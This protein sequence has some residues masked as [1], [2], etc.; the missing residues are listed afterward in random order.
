M[1]M[2][3]YE[4]LILARQDF[5]Q[6]AEDGDCSGDCDYCPFKK[7]VLGTEDRIDREPSYYCG[8]FDE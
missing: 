3:D 6:D 7:V 1:S 5:I 8:L 2:I 4:G